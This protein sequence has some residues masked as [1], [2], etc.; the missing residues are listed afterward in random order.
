[1]C[2]KWRSLNNKLFFLNGLCELIWGV[3]GHLNPKQSLDLIHNIFRTCM[4]WSVGYGAVA[5]IHFLQSPNEI[6]QILTQWIM[7]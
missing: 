2:K 1:M 3:L 4:F 5:L 7:Q 6:M